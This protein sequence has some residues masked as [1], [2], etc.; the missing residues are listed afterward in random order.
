MHDSISQISAG[1]NHFV[2]ISITTGFVYTWGLG[3]A[4]LG[5]GVKEKPHIS[6]PHLVTQLLPERGGV[7]DTDPYI[8]YI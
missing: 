5:H 6:S 3:A 7:F 2:G 8:L 1:A 4:Q